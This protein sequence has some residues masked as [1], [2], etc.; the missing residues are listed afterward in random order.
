VL[1]ATTQP[2]IATCI[3]RD[4]KAALVAF[5]T[6]LGIALKQPSWFEGRRSFPSV[7]G[8][9]YAASVKDCHAG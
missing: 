1:G 7:S 6:V 9:V 2:C 3:I 5:R 8:I 4:S